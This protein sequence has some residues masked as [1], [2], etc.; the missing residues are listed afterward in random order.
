MTY[1]SVIDVMLLFL[2]GDT[3]LLALRSGTGFA[4]GWWNLPSGKLDADE[5]AVA[6]VCRESREEVGILLTR[7]DLSLASTVHFR[8]EHGEARLG[9]FFHARSW[10]GEPVNSEPHKCARIAWFPLDSLPE[11]TYPYTRV[12]IELCKQ[13]KNF[14]V[15]GWNI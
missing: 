5:D 9:L 3:V 7:D 11:N 13:K 1:R 2:R 15:S 14:T 4:D 8:N 10:S 6:A 12:G